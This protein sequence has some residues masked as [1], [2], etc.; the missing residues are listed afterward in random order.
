VRAVT[1]VVD[2]FILVVEWG[3]TR[4]NLVQHQLAASPELKER[5]L[6]VVLN[7]ANVRALARYAP[8]YGRNYYK[9]YYGR[10]GY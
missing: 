10:Y 2:S 6:G 7:K 9:Q 5:L 3:Q 8:Y 4:M 1:Q